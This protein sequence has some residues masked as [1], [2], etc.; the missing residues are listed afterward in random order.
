MNARSESIAAPTSSLWT[1]SPAASDDSTRSWTSV[2]MRFEPARA[3]QRD[4]V[5]RQ[6]LRVEDPVA[7]RVVDV[8]VDVRD[9]VDDAHDLALVR[10]R[11]DLARVLEDPVAH[12]PRQV[13]RLGDPERLLVVAEAEAEA[14]AQARVERL[15]ARRGRTACAPCRGRARSPRSGPRSAAGPARRRAR[16]PVVS[17]VCVIRVRKWSPAGS[18]KT[19]VLPFSRRNGFEWRIRSRSRWN[20]VRS[21]ALVLLARAPA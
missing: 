13:E 9:P 2:S 17:S 1:M 15:L 7:D 19:C 6:V 18:M 14:L 3:E 20:G 10:L 11:L 8:V 5:L 12:L 4:L 16:S 21:A